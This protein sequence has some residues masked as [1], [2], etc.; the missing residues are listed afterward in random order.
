M[1]E[2]RTAHTGELDVALLKTVRAFLE[3]VFEGD[4]SDQDWDHALGG[5]HVLAWEGS[6]LVGHAS[7]VQRRLLHD[8]RALRTGYV[9]CV[10]VRADR[11]RHGYGAIVMD[12]LERLLRGAYELGALGASDRAVRFYQARGWKA[13]QGP[14]SV[15]TPTGIRRTADQDGA[16]HV[17]PLG[18]PLDLAGELI[19]DWREGAAW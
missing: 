11:R 7:L 4:L 10:G 12:A 18:A 6:E 14:T 13:W 8:R 2:L 5:M 1:I 16:V 19:S 17:L 9:E 3:D 15:L